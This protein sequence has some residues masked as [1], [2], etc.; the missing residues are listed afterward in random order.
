MANNTPGIGYPPDLNGSGLY[1]DPAIDARIPEGPA[2][3]YDTLLYTQELIVH[4]GV[5]RDTIT[6]RIT[7]N[8][9]GNPGYTGKWGYRSPIC[10]FPFRIDPDSIEIIDTNADTSV[11]MDNFALMYIWHQGQDPLPA[12]TQR[13]VTFTA[14][15]VG[16]QE[17]EIALSS[18]GRAIVLENHPNPFSNNTTIKFLLNKRTKVSLRIYD[19]SGRLVKTLINDGIMDTG[20]REIKWDGR[21]AQGRE[22]SSGVYFY[23]LTS[24]AVTQTRKLVLLK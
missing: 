22:L 2:Y 15:T 20:Y 14:K 12:G 19:Y 1:G 24:E 6:F 7:M 16:V 8:K 9:D 5:Q 17:K 23:R 18:P 11:I 21:D 10:L 13:W 4:E 3:T